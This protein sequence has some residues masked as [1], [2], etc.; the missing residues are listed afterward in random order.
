MEIAES[1]CRSALGDLIFGADLQTLPEAVADLLKTDPVALKWAPSVSTA[2]SCTGGLVA[3]ML[4]DVP[5]S[6]AYFR[7][8]CVTYSN[9]AKTNLLSVPA[10]LIEQNGAVSEP[11]VRAMAIGSQQRSGAA[12]AL[13]ITGVAGPGGGTPAKPVGSVWIALA[14]P[15]GCDARLFLFPGDREMVRDRAAKMALTLLRFHLLGKPVPF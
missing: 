4:T 3:K 13:A 2:E 1:A 14:H 6:S 11:V 10:E 9:E 5:G 15:Q 12:Y 8:G 7:Q